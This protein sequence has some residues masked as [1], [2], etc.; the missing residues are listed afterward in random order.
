M[1]AIQQVRYSLAAIVRK[2]FDPSLRPLDHCGPASRGELDHLGFTAQRIAL[3]LDETC[4]FENVDP[5][6]ARAQGCAG[7]FGQLIRRHAVTPNFRQE[8]HEQY[9]PCRIGEDFWCEEVG[10]RPPR[11]NDVR[12]KLYGL[13][14]RMEF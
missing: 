5:S 8:K 1:D 2:T 4:A 13:R 12:H 11:V 14:R 10:A 6:N 9:V 7:R 3:L